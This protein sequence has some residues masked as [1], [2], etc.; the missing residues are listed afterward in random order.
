M[1]QMARFVPMETRIPLMTVDEANESRRRGLSPLLKTDEWRPLSASVRVEIGVRSHRGK[2]RQFN[3]DHYL[4][5]RLGRYQE[6]LSTSLVNAD[7]PSRLDEFGYALLVADGLGGTGSGA[8]ASRLAL[9][10]LAHIALHFGQWNLRID[11]QTAAE[12][13]ERAEWF[14]RRVDEAVTRHGQTQPALSGMATTLTA[15][16]S[17][18]NDLFVAHVGHSRAYLFRDGALTQLTRDQ[19]VQRQV[20]DTGRPAPVDRGTRDLRH[21]L[22][23]TIGGPSGVPLIHVEHFRLMNGDIVLLCTDGLTDMVPD[24]EIADVLAL[25]RQPD[26]QCQALIDAALAAGGED[27][28]T[29]LLGQYEIPR[30]RT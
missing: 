14:Y 27:N 21:I 16:Y 4:V 30:D 20:N 29:A 28:L 9:S 2:V 7:L 22:T 13:V 15:A 10:T 6:T 5:L 3:E 12:V 11:A 25:R 19:T 1:E 24:A 18:G 8:V 26:E 17:A 23:D